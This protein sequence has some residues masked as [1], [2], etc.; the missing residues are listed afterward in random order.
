VWVSCRGN[1]ELPPNRMLMSFSPRGYLVEGLLLSAN[2]T[3]I[4]GFCFGI[5]LKHNRKGAH[6]AHQLTEA[7]VALVTSFG[8]KLANVSYTSSTFLS[9]RGHFVRL[10]NCVKTF[11]R[12]CLV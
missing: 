4:E 3:D 2:E 10:V 6:W 12:R 8:M 7:T 11:V 1:G 9:H 5:R